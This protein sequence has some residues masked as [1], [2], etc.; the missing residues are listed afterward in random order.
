ME[1]RRALFTISLLVLAASGSMAAQRNMPLR[2]VKA[3]H[4]EPT[5]IGNADKVKEDFAPSLVE[6]GLRNALR[7]SNF[8]IEED[9]PI[10]AHIVLDEFSSGSTAKRFIVGFGAGRSTVEGRLVFRDGEGTEIANV[11]IRVRGQLLFSSYQ[12][13]NTQ[14]RQASD[15]FSQKL[16]EEIARLK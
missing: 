9:A 10:K 2:G 5:V 14:R 15:G 16:R 1:I 11:K 7:D 12:G 3:V 6:D 13:G 4:V 8:E